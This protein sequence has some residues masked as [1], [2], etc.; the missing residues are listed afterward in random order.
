MPTPDLYFGTT[1]TIPQSALSPSPT[2]FLCH[3]ASSKQWARYPITAGMSRQGA[4][5]ERLHGDGAAWEECGWERGRW[6]GGQQGERGDGGASA[7]LRPA[8]AASEH[9]AQTEAAREGVWRNLC[10][11]C[12]AMAQ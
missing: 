8:A 12:G 11:S 7:V 2:S 5:G 4:G 1:L 9:L 3:R 10:V 6:W